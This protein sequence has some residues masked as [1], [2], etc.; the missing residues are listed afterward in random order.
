[1]PSTRP[2]GW[3]PVRLPWE[4]RRWEAVSRELHQTRRRVAAA[5]GRDDVGVL[6]L[7]ELERTRVEAERLVRRHRRAF[8]WRRAVRRCV[9]GVL[10]L[11]PKPTVR[12]A[13]RVVQ[14]SVPVDGGSRRDMAEE[15]EEL[16]VAAASGAGESG[17]AEAALLGRAKDE[18]LALDDERIERLVGLCVTQPRRLTIARISQELGISADLRQVLTTYLSRKRAAD[19]EEAAVRRA[20]ARFQQP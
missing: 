18:V 14:G 16:R 20:E 12:L 7:A 11:G 9:A 13:S 5:E 17:E 8:G 4:A 19:I 1:M 3:G 10:T 2:V 6:T 15:I